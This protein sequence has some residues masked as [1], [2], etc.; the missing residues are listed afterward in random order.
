MAGE[1]GGQGTREI[2]QA[3]SGGAAVEIAGYRLAPELFAAI[4]SLDM[5]RQAPPAGVRIRWLDVV[6]STDA[7][8]PLQSARL[9]AA[10]QDD[11][12]DLRHDTAVGEPFW[13]TTEIG[14]APALTDKTVDDFSR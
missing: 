1:G 12:A 3:L 7:T 9:A 8:A 11:G 5:R 4:E 2:R 13:G 6:A 10:W 14:Y